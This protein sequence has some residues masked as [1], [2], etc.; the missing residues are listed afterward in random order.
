MIF[1]LFRRPSRTGS[2]AALYGTIV[3]QARAAA[4]YRS[5]GV[6]DTVDGRLE[7]LILHVV[8]VLRRLEE[9]PEAWRALGQ[10]LFDEFCRDMDANLREMGVG[11]LAVPRRMHELGEAFYGRQAAYRSALAAV[12]D[13]QALADALRRNVFAGRA[14]DPGRLA[15]YLREVGRELA[16]QDSFERGV[17][18][19]PDPEGVAGLTAGKR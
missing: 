6:P 19:F 8:L 17:V 7:M 4:F 1:R 2:I 11:D 18:A 16:G 5:Y 10:R 15:A 13:G 3:A 9:G 14:V 12:G